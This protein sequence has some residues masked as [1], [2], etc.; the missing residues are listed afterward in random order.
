MWAFAV[1]NKKWDWVEMWSKMPI[2]DEETNSWIG[3]GYL[4]SKGSS[5]VPLDFIEAVREHEPLMIS[6]NLHFCFIASQCNVFDMMRFYPGIF[7]GK[8]V[9]NDKL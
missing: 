5:E 6:V 8:K 2:F 4:E 7:N 9:N 3:D 1:Y